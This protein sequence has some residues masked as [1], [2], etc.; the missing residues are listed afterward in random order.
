ML[1]A[2]DPRESVPCDTLAKPHIRQLAPVK[3]P[4]SSRRPG[5]VATV[6]ILAILLLAISVRLPSRPDLIG[7][8]AV[9]AAFLIGYLVFVAVTL[10]EAGESR[11]P[12]VRGITI[13]GLMFALYA[14]LARVAF[15]VTPWNADP[16]LDG[17]DRLL[18]MGESP[19]LWAAENTLANS[20]RT[21]PKAGKCSMTDARSP[22]PTLVGQPVR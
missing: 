19:V 21:K 3:T 2:G 20:L 7:D 6:A 15:E 14:T 18:F 8:W 16:A 22:V 10:G 17:F 13:V 12:L 9:Q 5:D 11:F 4:W 1:G